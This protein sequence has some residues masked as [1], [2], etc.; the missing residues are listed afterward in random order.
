MEKKQ[1]ISVVKPLIAAALLFGSS[2]GV[3]WGQA[4]IGTSTNDANNVNNEFGAGE[5]ATISGSPSRTGYITE[6]G[7]SRTINPTEI[8]LGSSS[9]QNIVI[10]SYNAQGGFKDFVY[11]GTKQWDGHNQGSCGGS[12]PSYPSHP[13]PTT[14]SY[15]EPS[16]P[17]K[18]CVIAPLR[19]STVTISHS[20]HNA[21]I[22]TASLIGITL[23]CGGTF[24]PYVRHTTASDDGVNLVQLSGLGNIEDDNSYINNINTPAKTTNGGGLTDYK[25]PT[26]VSIKGKNTFSEFRIGDIRWWYKTFNVVTDVRDGKHH[27][28]DEG[29]VQW[30]TSCGLSD[31]VCHRGSYGAYVRQRYTTM[32]WGGISTSAWTYIPRR[33]YSDNGRS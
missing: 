21:A 9:A 11:N 30:Y 33:S 22:K 1:L 5:S 10:N 29:T 19:T 24:T 6:P 18:G 15:S 26:T 28:K 27:A 17:E 8:H 2:G 23:G 13:D 7:N 3:A 25:R 14:L 16:V 20:Y 31:D 32:H 12:C 4:Y